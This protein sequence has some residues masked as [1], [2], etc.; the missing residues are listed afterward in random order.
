METLKTEYI[1][2]TL[3]I[4]YLTLP[5]KTTLSY[6]TVPEFLRHTVKRELDRIA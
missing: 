6:L 2:L 3:Q 1:I 5:N 4:L